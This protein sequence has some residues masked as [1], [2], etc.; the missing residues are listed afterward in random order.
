MAD[1][2]MPHGPSKVTV[3]TLDHGPITLP[4]P[5]WCTGHAAAPAGYRVDICHTGTETGLTAESDR[6]PVAILGSCLT[7]YP[8][9]ALPP[10]ATPFLAV[11]LGDRWGQFDPDGLR[12]FADD[13]TG[14]ADWLRIRAHQLAA[15]LN[16]G[17]AGQA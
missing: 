7:Q 10:G 4:E 13:L 14:Y 8:F 6:G 2:A 17:E 16:S 12:A 5:S 3:P 9:S 15:I 1:L 11:D